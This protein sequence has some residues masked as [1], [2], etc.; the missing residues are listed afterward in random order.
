MRGVGAPEPLEPFDEFVELW[1][2]LLAETDAAGTVVVV[3]GER[4][5]RAVRRLG[6]TGSVVVVHRGRPISA[7]ASGLVASRGKVI[8]LTDW[9]T[10]GGHLARRLRDF[11]TAEDVRLDLDYR[12][13]LARILRGELTHVEG[14]FGWA[15]R[16]AERR[17]EPLER[18]T[19]GADARPTG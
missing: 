14:L 18:L 17:G 10:E 7:T 12:R 8:V 19:E 9:D 1:G 3:E 15:R 13:R 6:W 11:L 4:D 5:R 16:Q 2:K